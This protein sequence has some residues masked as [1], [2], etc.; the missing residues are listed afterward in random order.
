MKRKYITTILA[1]ASIFAFGALTE[2]PDEGWWIIG[3]VIITFFTMCITA[4]VAINDW[5]ENK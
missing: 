3:V 5:F 4:A 2:L 1:V